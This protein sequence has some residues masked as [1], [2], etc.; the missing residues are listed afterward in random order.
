MSSRNDF[1]ASSCTGKK[2]YSVSRAKRLARE[3]SRRH[4]EPMQAY[5]CTFCHG[6]HLGRPGGKRRKHQQ[7]KIEA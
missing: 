4:D 2:T 3:V 7:E 5:H 6:W 1:Q